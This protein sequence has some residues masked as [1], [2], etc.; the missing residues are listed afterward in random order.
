MESLSTNV[1][2]RRSL[3]LVAAATAVTALL[4]GIARLG[5]ALGW[6]PSVAVQ[7]GPLLVVGVFGTVISLERAVALTKTWAFAAP[8]LSALGAVSMMAGVSFAPWLSVA[9]CVVVVLVNAVIIRRQAAAFTWLMLLGSL[10]LLGG[11]VWWARGAAVFEVVPAWMAFFVLTI[12]AERLE[13]S[14]LAPTPR[15]ASSVLVGVSILCAASALV[16]PWWPAVATPAFG[17]SLVLLG[18]WQL[19]FDLAR[20]TVR[21]PGLPRFTALGVLVGAAWLTFAGALNLL[22]GRPPAGPLADAALHG[23]FVGYVLS[24]V[25]AHAPI[26]LP[27]VARVA[28]PFHV[29]LYVPLTVLH[30]GLALRIGGDLTSHA[31]LRQAGG[32]LNVFALLLFGATVVVARVFFAVKAPPRR[33]RERVAA[34]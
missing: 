5:V 6:G 16:Q 20:R 11:T 25:F 4:G 17:G 12:V 27:A 18:V 21:L 30:V 2:V 24:M 26:I 13:L 22:A 14:R 32:V 7:H 33:A 28:V 10:A 34:R 9:S 29:V 3:L 1:W 15:W 19:S 31:V 8:A 23:V